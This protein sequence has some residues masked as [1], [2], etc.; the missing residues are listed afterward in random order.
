MKICLTIFWVL[1]QTSYTSEYFYMKYVFFGSS[2]QNHAES[3]GNYVNKSLLD[4]K[5][6]KSW[7]LDMSMGT[8]SS[9]LGR[10]LPEGHV[11]SCLEDHKLRL[12]GKRSRKITS[13]QKHQK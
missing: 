1:V 12:R 9:K 13:F 4:P 5:H 8:K 7:N 2:M 6:N 11:L 10:N 3:F